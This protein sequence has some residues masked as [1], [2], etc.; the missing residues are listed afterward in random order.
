MA[1]FMK[2]E[3]KTAVQT[4]RR[5]KARSLLTMFGIIIG[6]MSVLTVVGI[7]EGVKDQ[8]NAQTE[9]LGSDLI[10]VRP[11]QLLTQSMSVGALSGVNQLSYGAGGTLSKNDVRTAEKTPGVAVTVPLSVVSGGITSGEN[12]RQDN[13]LVIGTTP[14]LPAMLRQGLAFGDFFDADQTS[15]NKVVIGSHVAQAL[16]DENVPLGQTLSIL[17]HQFIVVG[18]LNDFQTTPLSVDVD[19]NNAVFIPYDSAVSVTN[20]SAP[21]YEILVR[22][23]R[24]S[25]TAAVA[26][27]LNG[28][29]LAAHGGQHDFTVL[30]QSQTIM[31]T[32]NILNLLT[33]LIAGVAAISLLVGGV[34][35]MNVMLVSVTER[36][37]EIGIRKA[38]G[39]TNRQ[40]LRQFMVEAAVLSVTG[41][42]IGVVLS[43]AIEVCMRLLTNLAPDITWQAVL[44]ACAVSISVG[45]LFGSFPALKAARKDPISALRNE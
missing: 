21:I 39:A 29:L 11:G 41:G 4:L 28:S 16:Y 13:A 38:V 15:V 44:A 33:L 6:V 24:V 36:M 43:F 18:I 9:R 42:L 20:G 14:D 35:I 7:G 45:I 10:T 31:V 2:G 32:N 25:D 3:I 26:G 17:G 1:R 22:P 37:H 5:N 8:V 40:I 30:Q 12:N 27:R 34:G 23:S 19:F